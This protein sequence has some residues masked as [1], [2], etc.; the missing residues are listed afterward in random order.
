MD[1]PSLH[2]SED[3]VELLCELVV[4]CSSCTTVLKFSDFHTVRIV[5]V[6]VDSRTGRPATCDIMEEQTGEVLR[7][8][9][10]RTHEL[11]RVFYLCPRSEL[12][13]DLAVHSV[14]VELVVSVTDKT[15]VLQITGTD[16]PVYLVCTTRE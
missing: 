6:R 15:V 3:E 16:E 8:F 9:V 4:A 7:L 5:S 2:R 10:F 12:C 14:A 11:G 1:V 13:V